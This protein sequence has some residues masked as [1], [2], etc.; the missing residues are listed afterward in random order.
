MLAYRLFHYHLAG[1]PLY[2]FALYHHKHVYGYKIGGSIT[3]YVDTY[4]LVLSN[5][6]LKKLRQTVLNDI[7]NI[8]I[9]LPVKAHF[10]ASQT[11]HS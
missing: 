4:H 10:R 9:G 2:S 1:V 7:V 5:H 3:Q 8:Q 11:I 6:F